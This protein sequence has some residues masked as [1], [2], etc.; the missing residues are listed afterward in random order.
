MHE[1]HGEA[2]EE[3]M[4]GLILALIWGI[5]KESFNEVSGL[6]IMPLTCQ[7]QYKALYT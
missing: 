5:G 4:N 1:I 7:K 3:R 6:W 2:K